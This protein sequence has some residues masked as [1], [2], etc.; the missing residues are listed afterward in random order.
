M[1]HRGSSI[2]QTRKHRIGYV[3]AACSGAGI[4]W[5]V[6][7]LWFRWHYGPEPI[8]GF[9]EKAVTE[10]G[11]LDVVAMM[12]PLF[13]LMLAGWVAISASCEIWCRVAENT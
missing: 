13:V 11:A 3:V 1:T 9:A 12:V 4:G 7:G 2:S 10:E 6:T 5:L 8:R